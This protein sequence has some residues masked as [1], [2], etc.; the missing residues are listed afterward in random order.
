MAIRPDNHSSN[1]IF[2]KKNKMKRYIIKYT[3]IAGDIVKTTTS[4]DRIFEWLEELLN[5]AYV[6]DGSIVINTEEKES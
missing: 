2:N 1:R 6:A 4:I 3:H 5:D